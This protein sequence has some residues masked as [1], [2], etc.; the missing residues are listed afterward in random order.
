MGVETLTVD[1]AR[2]AVLEKQTT[3]TALVDAFY[4]KI[5]AEDPAIGAYLTLSK[6][7]A[8]RQAEHVDTL[9]DKGDALPPLAGVP[10]AIKDVLSTR[11]VRTTAGSK[12]LHNFIAPY[13]A[14]AVAR[15]ETAGAI[16]LGKTN[17]DEFAMGSSN[18][19]SGFYPVKNPRNHSRV[20]GGS[21]GGSAATVAAGTAVAAL[22]TDTGGSI[23]QPAAF[24][25]VVGLKPTYGRVSRYGLI[26]FASSL[27]HVGPLGKTVKDVALI[28]QYMAGH[29]SKDSTSADLPVPNYLEPI[30][31]PVTGLKVGVPKEYFGAGLDPQVRAAVEGGIQELAKAGCEIVAVSLPHTEYAIPTYYL[32]A[33]AEAS[34]N[35]ARFDGVRYGLR[36]RDAKTLAD[37]Y[38]NT[39]DAGFGTEVKRRIMLGTYALSAGYYDAYYLK[40]QKVRALLAQDFDD[41]FAK[42]DVIV[43][44]TTPTPA[45]KLGEKADDP[46]AM[47]LADI[48]TVTAN[49]AGVPGITVPCGNSRDGLPIGLQILGKHFDEATVLKTGHVVEHALAGAPVQVGS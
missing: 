28:L 19:N 43:T 34:S 49:L 25:G 12:I 37:M 45:F 30:G 39:R 18:E 33:T 36:A 8:Y 48:Y 38:R 10:V 17:C 22:G 15:L 11:G 46:L 20:P 32:V 5:K 9:A 26:A 13:D 1:S 6:E 21:S 4:Q 41:T 14:T 24:C 2:T 35:L 3:A 40:A 42:V 29:D 23:R 27:D 7:R 16:V 44:P 31:Q 47:Y